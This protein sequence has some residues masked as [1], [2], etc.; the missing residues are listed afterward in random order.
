MQAHLP[1]GDK[2]ILLYVR[3]YTIVWSRNKQSTQNN[4]QY[5]IQLHY[6]KLSFGEGNILEVTKVKLSLPCRE[7]LK[8]PC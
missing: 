4:L 8:V 6:L 5:I 2:Q 3:T 7:N 1:D